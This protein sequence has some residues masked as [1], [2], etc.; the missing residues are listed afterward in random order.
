MK[1]LLRIVLAVVAVSLFFG[2]LLGA[3]GQGVGSIELL[4]IVVAYAIT[5]RYA[6]RRALIR[7]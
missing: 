5:L 1:K 2:L 4:V 3:V 6:I 7:A